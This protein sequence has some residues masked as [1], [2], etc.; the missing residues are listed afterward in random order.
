MIQIEIPFPIKL[1][2]ED[3]FHHIEEQGTYYFFQ[4]MAF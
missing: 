1:K 2:A 3:L 4:K